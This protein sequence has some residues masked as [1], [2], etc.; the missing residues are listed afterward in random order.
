[1]IITQTG[2]VNMW[3]THVAARYAKLARARPYALSD[4]AKRWITWLWVACEKLDEAEPGKLFDWAC[5]K[6]ADEAGVNVLQPAAPAEMKPPEMWKD[7]WGNP[8]PNPFANKDLKGQTL[9]QQRDPELAKWLKAYAESPYA[10]ASEW[11]DR[12]AALLKQKTLTYDADTHAINPYVN[13]ANETERG[14]FVKNASPEVAERCKWEAAPVTF[15]TAKDFNLTATSKIATVPRLSALWGA[16]NEQE[17]EYVVAE[18]TALQQQRSAAET[19][20]KALEA[21]SGTAEPPRIASRVRIGA[22]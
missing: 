15:P 5:E 1:M 21:A 9:L 19:R 10:A 22:E 20:L 4:D 13:G 12:T 14:Q 17:R 3:K 6:F 7:I 18:K 8:L 11:A 2:V 16:M